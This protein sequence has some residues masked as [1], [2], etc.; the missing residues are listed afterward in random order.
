MKKWFLLLLTLSLIPLDLSAQCAMCRAQLESMGD[1]SMA[2]GVNNGIIVLMAAS[3][4]TRSN[5][6]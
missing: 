3:R 2:E 4:L 6:G 5:M 1:N